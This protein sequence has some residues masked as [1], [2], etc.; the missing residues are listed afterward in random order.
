M[1][2][3]KSLGEILVREKL[4]GIDDLETARRDQRANGG[5]LITS[6]VRLGLVDEIKLTEILGKYYGLPV[7]DLYSFEVDP[8]VIKMI[9]KQVC[10]KNMI[11]P[12]SQAGKS[13]VVAF[14]DPSNLYLKDDLAL[15]TRSKIEVVVASESSIQAAIEKHYGSSGANIESLISSIEDA[16]A[17]VS[18]E[19]SNVE[20]VDD[21]QGGADAPIIRFV[22]AILTEAIR[23][24][25]SDIHVEPYEK[26]FRIRYRID[27]VLVERTQ[28]PQNSAT[29]IT[30]RL[31][32]LAKLNISERRKP[33]DGRMKVRLKNGREVDFRVSCLPTI[34]GEKVVLRLL[35]KSNLQVDLMALGMQDNQL[36]IFR[37]AINLPQGM[38]LI[39]G[40]TGSGKTTTIYSALAQLNLP[41]VNLS[42]A[43]DPVEF[44]LD[45]INQ[46]QVNPSVGFTFAE[47]LR[48]FLRQDP[49]IIMVG[50]IR[51]L[52]TAEVAY[53]A[54]STGHMVVSTLHT[55][56]SAATISRLVEMGLEPYVVAEATS[57][58]VAQRLL[59]QVCSHCVAPAKVPAEIL[60]KLGVPEDEL[61]QYTKLLKGEG[62]ELCNGT[63]LRGRLAVF[64]VMKLGM[65]LKEAIYKSSSP[66]TLKRTAISEGMSTL[67]QSA[68]EMLKNGKTTVE[69]V[70]M[71]TVGDDV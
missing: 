7:L 26:R 18:A 28:P 4:I 12:V 9:S 64:E 27:G 1:G 38:V 17:D 6:L 15:M 42:T 29:A 35:D 13:L 59:R 14:S 32:I 21:D 40:P 24:K 66:L 16:D 25:A 53:K 2:A 54:A 39:T 37:D 3:R 67:R 48:S 69:E 11:F 55:N 56:D 52:E 22:N 49:E 10:E 65:D 50:E 47:A 57:L 71:N 62:C 30:N 23:S 41:D 34:F 61:G 70:A 43:E 33:Q 5:R 44:N 60:V 45:G 36:E 8:D 58:V 51:D 31:K 20:F 63:G 46:V 68:L 19:P